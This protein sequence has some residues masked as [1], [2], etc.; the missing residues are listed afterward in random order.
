[1]AFKSID[2][3]KTEIELN[4]EILAITLMIQEKYPE[5]SK[6]L[7]E[8]PITIPISANPEINI[9]T[10]QSYC[11]SLNVLVEKYNFHIKKLEE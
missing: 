1:L 11:N 4:A 8:M 2:I 5:L 9:N 3:M 7:A 6:Y 10:L